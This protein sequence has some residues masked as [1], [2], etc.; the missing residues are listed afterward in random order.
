MPPKPLNVEVDH[1]GRR[2]RVTFY[3]DQ[4][5]ARC[6]GVFRKKS[7]GESAIDMFDVTGRAVINAARGKRRSRLQGT[8][9]KGMG[10]GAGEIRAMRNLLLALGVIAVCGCFAAA[11]ACAT[12]GLIV[13]CRS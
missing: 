8:Q 3:G 13:A 4:V 7:G 5:G 2:Y 6:L 12:I 11:G 9:R 1:A 10:G